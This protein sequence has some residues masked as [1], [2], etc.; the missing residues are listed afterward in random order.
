MRVLPHAAGRDAVHF[1]SRRGPNLSS[2]D[3]TSGEK[4]DLFN[5]RLH[6]WPEH[7][8]LSAGRIIGLT[9]IG[10]ATVRLLNMNTPRRVELRLLWSEEGG[11]Y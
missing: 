6:V 10:R 9:P 4:V 2:I 5:P 1:V 8:G 7:F 3:P 11:S